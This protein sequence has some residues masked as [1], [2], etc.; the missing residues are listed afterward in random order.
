MAENNEGH[1]E[2]DGYEEDILVEEIH[3]DRD[4]DNK[5]G[6]ST[7]TQQEDNTNKASNNIH[8]THRQNDQIL[9]L[10][11]RLNSMMDLMKSIINQQHEY[12]AAEI[13]RRHSDS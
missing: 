6:R 10:S 11:T 1:I 12:F 8:L 3:V 4:V 9:F 5:A 13:N 2:Q 7:E